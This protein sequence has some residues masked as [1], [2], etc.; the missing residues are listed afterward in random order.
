MRDLNDQLDQLSEDAEKSL[1]VEEKREANECVTIMLSMPRLDEA[2]TARE[3]EIRHGQSISVAQNFLASSEPEWQSLFRDAQNYK[4]V[5]LKG[6]IL[7]GISIG[8]TCLGFPLTFALT[9][10]KSGW[11]NFVSLLLILLWLGASAAGI[12]FMVKSR[13]PFAARYKEL[14]TQRKNAIE[15]LRTGTPAFPS[16]EFANYSL[17]QLK[18]FRNRSMAGVIRVLERLGDPGDFLAAL[19]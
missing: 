8:F 5:R 11:A 19:N 16:P 12:Y 15:F 1:S 14:E 9:T 17:E 10:M 6:M 4:N 13:S 7:L 18:D 3:E 2:I